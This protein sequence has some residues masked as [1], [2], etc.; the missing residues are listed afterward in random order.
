VFL[1]VF[2]AAPQGL[3]TGLETPFEL[4]DPLP[5]AVARSPTIGVALGEGVRQLK[6]RGGVF[7]DRGRQ[8]VGPSLPVLFG[9]L[10]RV[11]KLIDLLLQRLG[12]SPVLGLSFLQ[13][14]G[15][16][17]IFASS[18]LD[19]PGQTL[20]FGAVGLES[21][22][23]QLLSLRRLRGELRVEGELRVQ[24]VAASLPL[25]VFADDGLFELGQPLLER[26][27]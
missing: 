14:V 24:I 6:A 4:V 2:L 25:R 22:L 20:F 21:S 1:P 18:L 11:F 3:F 26:V 5:Q 16:L 23:R 13:Q 19:E 15:Q 7:R 17:L 8:V 10:Q 12:C 9:G 27:A